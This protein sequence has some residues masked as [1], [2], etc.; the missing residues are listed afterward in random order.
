MKQPKHVTSYREWDFDNFKF[1]VHELFLYAIAIF[2]KFEQFSYANTLLEQ[3]YY[4]PENSEYG[5]DVMVGFT[6]FHE[7]MQSLE[8][9]NKRLGLHRLSIRA[10]LLKERCSGVGVEFRH[11]LQADFVIFMRGALNAEDNYNW[12]WPETLLYIGHFH[13]SFEIFARSVSQKYFDRV[14]ILLSIDKPS[15]LD[16]LLNS[17]KEGKRQLPKWKFESFSP[18]PLLGYEKLAT[19]P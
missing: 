16:E 15:D 4:L 12:W 19:R 6:V 10:D 5:H 11:L 2:L 8:H 1:I 18:S 14:K 9:R 3:K 7:Y 17:Y 13:A